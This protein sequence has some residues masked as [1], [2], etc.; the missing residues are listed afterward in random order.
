MFGI[1]TAEDWVR[2]YAG[3]RWSGRAEPGSTWD[4][5]G[6]RVPGETVL[7]SG[8]RVILTA[9]DVREAKMELD[10][11]FGKLADAMAASRMLDQAEREEFDE[12]VVAWRTFFCGGVPDGRPEPQVEGVGLSLQMN[13]VDQFDR[14]LRVWRQRLAARTE[15]GETQEDRQ[16]KQRRP[17]LVLAALA[18]AFYFFGPLR[19]EL[20]YPVTIRSDLVERRRQQ[21]E[22]MDDSDAAIDTSGGGVGADL[23]AKVNDALG[24]GPPHAPIADPAPAETAQVEAEPEPAPQ[25]A[26][27][28]E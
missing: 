15:R 27:T 3:P 4:E 13:T 16:E 23:A 26:A 22:R 8:Q 28:S 24:I 14:A 9:S 6:R 20:V 7:C 11:R 5:Q 1:W 10:G 19:R 21:A 18:G 2:H 25:A 12:L 17:V